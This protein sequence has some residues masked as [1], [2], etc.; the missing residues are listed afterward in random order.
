MADIEKQLKRIDNAWCMKMPHYNPDNLLT[1]RILST[2][3]DLSEQI[4][5]CA[6]TVIANLDTLE[7][8]LQR[9][10]KEECGSTGYAP[11]SQIVVRSTDPLEMTITFDAELS[12][13]ECRFED[14]EC[15]SLTSC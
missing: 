1:L 2:D 4:I 3:I 11:V 8:E 15:V 13:L 5:R 7:N 12:E 6:K 10:T 14:F 9:Y